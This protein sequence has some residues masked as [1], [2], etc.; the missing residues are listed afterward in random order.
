MINFFKVVIA[1]LILLGLGQSCQKRQRNDFSGYN[2]WKDI[3][4]LI[5][6]DSLFIVNVGDFSSHQDSFIEIKEPKS[7]IALPALIKIG[8]ISTLTSYLNIIKKRFKHKAII[9]SANDINPRYTANTKRTLIPIDAIKVPLSHFGKTKPN[10]LYKYPWVNSNVLNIQT[11]KPHQQNHL[12]EKVVIKEKSNKLVTITAINH[13]NLIK[14]KNIN[15]FYFRDSVSTFLKYEKD[16]FNIILYHGPT[17]CESSVIEK[18]VSFK[19]SLEYQLICEKLDPLRVLV[20]RLPP[21]SIDLIVSSLNLEGAG[22]INKT[23]VIFS[24]NSKNYIFPLLLNLSKSEKKSFLMPPIK[25]CHQMLIATKDCNLKTFKE[26]DIP[27]IEQMGPTLMPV[28]FLG[29]DVEL[30]LTN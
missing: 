14:G 12:S 3:D 18:P 28:K 22:F 29:Y 2:N 5:D 20:E 6:H 10:E 9:L 16:H 30:L 19:K 27:L 13:V 4:Q 23:P 21:G 24:G 7:E 8:G 15:G 1:T 25:L 26:R 17:A 11:G